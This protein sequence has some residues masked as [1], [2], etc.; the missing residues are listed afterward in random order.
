MSRI[1]KVDSCFTCPYMIMF[2][3]DDHVYCK[4]YGDNELE[5]VDL[6]D[7]EQVFQS[8]Y[9]SLECELEIE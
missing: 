9:I 8:N 5:L 2:H 1:I 4:Y 7:K 6:G 3:G